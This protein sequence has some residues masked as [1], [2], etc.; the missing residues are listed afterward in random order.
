M[1]R[2]TLRILLLGFVVAACAADLQAGEWLDRMRRERAKYPPRYTRG[3]VAQPYVFRDREGKIQVR[4][5]YIGYEDHF[6]PP[7]Y[8]YYGYPHSGYFT[9][10]GIG[11]SP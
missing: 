6:P 11:G 8:L 7:A 10:L 5:T 1:K 4:E 2:W 9:G 3:S